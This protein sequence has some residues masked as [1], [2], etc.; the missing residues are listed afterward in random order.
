MSFLNFRK[1]RKGASVTELGLLAGLIAVL[2]ISAVS[3][4]GNRVSQ[5]FSTAGNSLNNVQSK[6][7]QADEEIEPQI[8]TSCYD[9]KQDQTNAAS[10]AYEIDPDGEAGPIE[11]FNVY[12][13]MTTDGGGYTMY[14]LSGGTSTS[15]QAEA[16]CTA[17][18]LELFVPR[19]RQHLKSAFDEYGASRLYLMG[20]YP[21]F[22]GAIC[23]D[24]HMNSDSCSAWSPTNGGHWYV[25]NYVNITEP[26]G[27]NSTGHSMAYTFDASGNIT[28]Y[29]DIQTGNTSTPT[30]Y[31]T[32]QWLCSSLEDKNIAKTW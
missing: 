4:T 7:N 8:Y 5:L 14:S 3:S 22:S 18:G 20:I 30:N 1:T 25:E 23:R 19:S 27:D 13:D 29:N 26:N 16:Q 2:I 15:P 24:V 10:G 21:T 32:T 12:C 17:V 31:T 9:I 11:A 6:L 28:H